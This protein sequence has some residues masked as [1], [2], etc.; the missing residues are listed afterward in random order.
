MNSISLSSNKP[1]NNKRLLKSFSMLCNK[2]L[3]NILVVLTGFNYGTAKLQPMPAHRL[4]FR[5]IL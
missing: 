3:I 4:L 1:Y 5:L 2:L